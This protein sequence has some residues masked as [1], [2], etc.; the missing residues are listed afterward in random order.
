MALC[1]LCQQVETSKDGAY[2]N[3]CY[4][5]TIAAM[6]V[7]K[8]CCFCHVEVDRDKAIEKRINGNL[9]CEVCYHLF[10]SVACHDDAGVRNFFSNAHANDKDDPPTW[11]HHWMGL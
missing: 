8:H 3:V 2:C 5:M 11:L 1:V 4:E 9:H 6:I 7:P 10:T